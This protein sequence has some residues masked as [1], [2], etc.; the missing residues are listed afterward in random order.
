MRGFLV[1]LERMLY[2]WNIPPKQ[3]EGNVLSLLVKSQRNLRLMYRHIILLT[4]VELAKEWSPS[5]MPWSTYIYV[6]HTLCLVQ[7]A[8]GEALGWRTFPKCGVKLSYYLV[9]SP[10]SFGEWPP[11]GAFTLHRDIEYCIMNHDDSTFKATS[12]ATI[13]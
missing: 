4:L 5:Y 6:H 8:L 13:S 3:K 7:F 1:Y 10:S 2:S 12:H 11:F 9:L